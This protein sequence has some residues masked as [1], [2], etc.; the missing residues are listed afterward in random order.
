MSLVAVRNC[1][2]GPEYT[3]KISDLGLGRSLYSGD[4]F[5]LDG[6]ET[7]PIRWMAWEA[8]LLVSTNKGGLVV[9][10]VVH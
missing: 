3:V 8:I 7:L 4:Y 10:T 1:L 6:R 9:R 5:D 2:V